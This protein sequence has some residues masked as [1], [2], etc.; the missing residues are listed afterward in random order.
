MSYTTSWDTIDVQPA[1][2]NFCTNSGMQFSEKFR[3]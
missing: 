3:Y 2:T 1:R